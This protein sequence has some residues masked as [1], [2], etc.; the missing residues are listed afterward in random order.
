MRTSKATI[1]PNEKPGLVRVKVNQSNIITRVRK[2]FFHYDFVPFDIF[3]VL[4]LYLKRVFCLFCCLLFSI[5]RA[6][7]GNKNAASFYGFYILLERYSHY[8]CWH[9]T[10]EDS[11]VFGNVLR[12]WFWA[13]FFLL[14]L[15]F[16]L[17]IHLQFICPC[18]DLSLLICLLAKMFYNMIS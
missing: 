12:K 3:Q 2:R 8:T 16:L 15:A 18:Y 14:F 13:I 7:L 6:K 11:F 9:V 17:E 10:A 1:L 4:A 5:V